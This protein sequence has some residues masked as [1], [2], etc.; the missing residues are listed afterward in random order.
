ML[1]RL[2]RAGPTD[3]TVSTVGPHG[4]TS[5]TGAYNGGHLRPNPAQGQHATRPGRPATYGGGHPDFANPADAYA[6]PNGGPEAAR[7]PAVGVTTND[8][9]YAAPAVLLGWSGNHEAAWRLPR[10]ADFQFAHVGRL[11]HFQK[12]GPHRRAEREARL[13][14]VRADGPVLWKTMAALRTAPLGNHRLMNRLAAARATEHI[15][16]DRQSSTTYNE[17]VQTGPRRFA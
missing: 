8:H 13:A 12:P 10:R 14:A 11:A 5:R 3:G 4:R 9:D 2:R 16:T 7:R 15:G 1:R 6:E 17:P